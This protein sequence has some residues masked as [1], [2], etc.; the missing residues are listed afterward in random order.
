MKIEHVGLQVRDLE[1]SRRFFEKYFE[2]KAG[3]KYVNPRTK[4]QSYFLS[5]PSSTE[6]ARIEICTRPGLRDH[7]HKDDFYGYAHLAF[8]LG[9]AEKVDAKVL[10]LTAAG[11]QLI[12]GP[13]IT[14]D[15]YYEAVILDDD[16]NQIEITV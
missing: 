9:S 14:G 8:S 4:F 2:A 15:G 12:S 13:R 10:E 6:N 3:E 7:K 1:N 5:F 11:Y 16:K